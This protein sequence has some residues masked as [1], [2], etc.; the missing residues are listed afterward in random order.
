MLPLCF[1]APHGWSNIVDDSDNIDCVNVSH[2]DDNHED[3]DDNNDNDA[4]TTTVLNVKLKTKLLF[5]KKT[6][7]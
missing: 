2:D 4:M 1:A 6:C 7:G 3:D 5:L